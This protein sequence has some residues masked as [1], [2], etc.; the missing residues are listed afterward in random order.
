MLE[1]Y[2]DGACSGNPG[3]GAWASIALLDGIPVSKYKKYK[4]YTTNNEM[5]LDGVVTTLIKLKATKH[6][7]IYTDSAYVCNGFNSWVDK[8]CL[9]GWITRDG[10]EIKN[11]KLW[12]MLYCIKK[13]ADI[14]MIKVKGH[15]NNKYNNLCDKVARGYIN[16][17]R[18]G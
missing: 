9:N 17:K 16:E 12:K 14:K 4:K 5:E 7:I 8:W 18:N 1:I 15:S 3:P 10:K 2:T 6:I 11:M 13:Q